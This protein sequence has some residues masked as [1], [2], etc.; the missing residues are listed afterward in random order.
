MDLST[1]QRCKTCRHWERIES[2]KATGTGESRVVYPPKAGEEWWDVDDDEASIAAR[3]LH[4]VRRCAHPKVLFYQRPDRD[5]AAI[6]DGSD[7]RALL[8]TGE[9]FGCSLFEG[10][11]E[12]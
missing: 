2:P 1:D 3:G 8:C 12:G 4:L 7:Y 6:F 9:D 11:G 10:R 5:G